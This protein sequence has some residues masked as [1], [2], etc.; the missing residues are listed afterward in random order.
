MW[1]KRVLGVLLLLVWLPLFAQEQSRTA[2]V[3]RPFVLTL[4]SYSA[5]DW[6]NG[7]QAGINQELV[8]PAR[9]DLYVDYMD[10][11]KIVAPEYLDMVRQILAVKYRNIQFDLVIA[12]DDTAYQFA[13][14]NRK[15]LWAGTPIVFCGV[16]ELRPKEFAGQ[17]NF[18]G[19]SENNDLRAFVGAFPKIVPG[20]KTLFVVRDDSPYARDTLPYLLEAIREKMP[21]LRVQFIENNI[22]TEELVGILERAPAD[23]AVFF[24]SFWRDKNGR[25][26][27]GNEVQRILNQCVVPVF[28]A[29]QSLVGHGAMGA[30]FV[31]AFDQGSAAGRIA[32]DIIRGTPASAIPAVVGPARRMLFDYVLLER[33]HIPR[34]ALPAGSMVINEPSSFY[35]Q[36]RMLVWVTVSV[37]TVL[38]LLA[39]SLVVVI[40]QRRRAV[41]GLMESEEKF[42]AAFRGSPVSMAIRDLESDRYIEIN[43]RLL[44]LMKC[45]REEVIGRTPVEIG[46]KID[47]DLSDLTGPA[48]LQDREAHFRRKD[49]SS[50]TCSYTSHSI[51]IAGREC[52]LAILINITERK[53]A[54]EAL[55]ESEFFFKESQRAAFVGSYKTDFITGYWESSEV[56][57]QI[58]GIDKSYTRNIAG[59]LDL[60]DASDREMMARYLE[61]E[62]VGQR[63]PFNKEY[64]I[65]R[66]SDREVRWVNGL[67]RV[68]FDARGKALSL[69]GTIQ[70]V[71]ER[72]RAEL[73]LRESQHFI[74][75]VLDTTP[76]IVY[77]YDLNERKNVYANHEIVD[78]LGY[79]PEAIAGLGDKLFEQLI[80]PDDLANVVEHHRK[81]AASQ[82]GY[83]EL[84]YRMRDSQ[85]K[86]RWLHS[87][88]KVF[89][90]DSHGRVKQIVGVAS[91]ITERKRADEERE[92]LQSQLNQSQKM[93]SVGRLAGGVA[94]DF[95]NMLTAIHMNAT[96]ARQALP[97]DSPLRESLDEILQCTNRSAELTQR[98]LAFARKQTVAPKV[99]DLNATVEGMLKML[100]RLIGED[101]GLLWKPAADLWSVKVDPSQ[102]D[103]VLANL[104]VNARDAI[105]GV[106]KV[107]IVTKNESYD[108]AFCASHPGYLPGR[109]VVLSV[110]DDGCGMD[111][112]VLGHLFE[113]FF[114][115]KPVGQGTGLG[116]AT[117]YGVV[118]QNRGFINVY[119]EPGHGTTFNISLPRHADKAEQVKKDAPAQL[120]GRGHETILLVE[121]EPAILQIAKRTLGMLG[122]TVLAAATPGEAIRLAEEHAGKVHLLMTDV[123]MPEMNGRDLAKRL[124][125]LYPTLKR[126]FMSGYT[127]DVIAHQ[128][129]L[130]EGINFIQK[131]FSMQDLAGKVRAALDGE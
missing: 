1:M 120:V 76:D 91:D 94:H 32:R 104:C 110:S 66:K 106:G 85:G 14:Q 29:H 43:D 69:I 47:P 124:L 115:T 61:D 122:Y 46:W 68:M 49:G 19:I 130:E 125:A 53:K 44:V 101:I 13:L 81:V 58:L 35:G 25:F 98:L 18:T 62:V 112:E 74:T 128:G 28:S 89:A 26:I 118:K 17:E 11:R 92:K 83:E 107:T 127:A 33:F 39:G 27:N 6:D 48:A 8:G 38:A 78:V 84:D 99:L 119:S 70:D 102:I 129:V 131:P 108:E 36:H 87:R 22:V 105:T 126:L 55:R 100:H 15:E 30:S 93:E 52:R 37:I 40:F 82:D 103:Q 60:V 4:H 111:K 88:D 20:I 50:V 121:D 116:L 23:S 5:S 73:E 42:A 114:T 45:K 75:S 34:D 90:R 3:R 72:K 117:V 67:G 86:W 80:H 97:I 77:I 51:R 7:L 123:V 57:D 63:Q 12:C 79:S 2:I 31:D 54:E 64:R 56:L 24:L 16:N 113:P 65:V 9:I 21:G 59:W 71:T 41:A 10:A 109:Y 96:L 95:N